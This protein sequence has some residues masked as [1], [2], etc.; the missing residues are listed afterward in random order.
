MR[1]Q[2]DYAPLTQPLRWSDLELLVSIKILSKRSKPRW[3]GDALAAAPPQEDTKQPYILRSY[4]TCVDCERW[5]FGKNDRWRFY[6]VCSPKPSHLPE[7]D[8]AVVRIRE[9]PLI[10][11]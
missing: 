9:E 8:P 2:P 6:Y 5:M 3:F 10:V 4:I 1:D 7:G 11:G